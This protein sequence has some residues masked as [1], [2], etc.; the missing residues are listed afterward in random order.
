MPLSNNISVILGLPFLLLEVSE[1]PRENYWP[2]IHH[3]QT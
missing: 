1:V 2:V 3:R